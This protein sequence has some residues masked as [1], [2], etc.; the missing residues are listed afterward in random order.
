M[1]RKRILNQKCWFTV[2]LNKSYLLESWGRPLTTAFSYAPRRLCS[3]QVEQPRGGSV[4]A[5][6]A[7]Y[8]W[9]PNSISYSGTEGG[10][11]SN[12]PPPL[13]R[14]YLMFE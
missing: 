11:I 3:L 12:F 14:E 4:L 7:V 6:Q 1:A 9:V 10:G 2:N 13:S 5:R 8:T